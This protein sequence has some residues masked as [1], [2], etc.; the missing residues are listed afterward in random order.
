MK[1]GNMSGQDKK[2]SISLIKKI[3]FDTTLGFRSLGVHFWPQ[4]WSTG[5]VLA[6]KFK[7]RDL[8]AAEKRDGSHAGDVKEMVWELE[9]PDIEVVNVQN[10]VTPCKVDRI[11]ES[12]VE[13]WLW[14]TY[15]ASK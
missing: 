3:T 11:C 8:A 1:Q 5:M 7:Y 10:E 15:E 9:L 6:S 2:T 13:S 14:A 4:I 12:R